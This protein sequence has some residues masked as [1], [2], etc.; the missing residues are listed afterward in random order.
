MTLKEAIQ[1]HQGKKVKIGCKHGSGFLFIG[2]CQPNTDTVMKKLSYG[3]D[4]RMY[5]RLNSMQNHINDYDAF[6]DYRIQ[7]FDDSYKIAVKN[8]NADLKKL[9][10]RLKYLRTKYDENYIEVKKCLAD[11][12]RKTKALESRK[13]TYRGDRKKLK[14]HMLADKKALENNVFSLKEHLF[15]FTNFAECEVTDDYRSIDP[16][17]RGRIILIDAWDTGKLWLEKEAEN[18]PK[19]KMLVETCY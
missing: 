4:D 15:N 1:Q 18:D 2:V 13:S 10:D 14:D 3:Y 17:F 19:I 11:I 16:D 6:I 12:S 5:V 7:T 9:R 8:L